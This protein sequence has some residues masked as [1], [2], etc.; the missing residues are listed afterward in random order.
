MR[1]NFEGIT[2]RVLEKV[3]SAAVPPD[4]F[5]N[6]RHFLE[7]VVRDFTL[8]AQGLTKDALQRIKSRLLHILPS[9]SPP[10]TTK[11]ADE[12]EKEANEDDERGCER[13]E[14]GITHNQQ[15]HGG[16][17]PYMSPA[18]SL[19]ASLLDKPFSRL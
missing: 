14:E 2:E 12:A 13:K 10:I 8:A 19:F 11:M 16:K 17:A 1:R 9:R 4:A 5:D 15:S 3:A 18:S 7:T 6:A